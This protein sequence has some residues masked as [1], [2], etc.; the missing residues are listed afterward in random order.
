MT[1]KAIPVR[2]IVRSRPL[3]DKERNEGCC[4]CLHFLPDVPQ[5]TI[6]K[7]KTFTYDYV[8]NSKHNHA[9]VYSAIR[10]LIKGVFKG[11]N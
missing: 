6:G 2:V 1:N 4:E 9:N 10:P 5:V 7:N 8:F 3:V 11:N